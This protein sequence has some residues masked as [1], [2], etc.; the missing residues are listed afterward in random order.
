VREWPRE[1]HQISKVEAVVL[2][3]EVVEEVHQ[4]LSD[5]EREGGADS[6]LLL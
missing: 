5:A 6:V 3:E 1:H 2:V 4:L